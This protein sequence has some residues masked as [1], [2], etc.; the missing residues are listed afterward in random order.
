MHPADSHIFSHRDVEHISERLKKD[1][2]FKLQALLVNPE[3]MDYDMGPFKRN[4]EIYEAG[5]RALKSI[6]LNK[7]ITRSKSLSSLS[8]S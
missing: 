7:G 8:I 5:S 1:G 3:I 4:R 6:N 2:Y